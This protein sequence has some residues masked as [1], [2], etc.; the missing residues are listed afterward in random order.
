MARSATT[1]VRDAIRRDARSISRI[2]RDAGVSQ[3]VVSRF[4][5]GQRGVTVTTVDRL[6]GTLGLELRPSRRSA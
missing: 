6:I 2:A 5:A 1:A 3:S 4:V